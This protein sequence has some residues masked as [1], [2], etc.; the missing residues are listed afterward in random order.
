MSWFKNIFSKS[1]EAAVPHVDSSVSSSHYD[2]LKHGLAK[3]RKRW[4]DGITS[5]LIGK[6]TLDPELLEALETH[7]LEADVG[8]EMTQALIEPL[9]EGLA[10]QQLKDGDTVF[11]TI[12]QQLI[13]RLE[14]LSQPLQIPNHV[15]PFLVLMVGVNGAGKTTTM[16]KLARM[17]QLEGKK[18]M[19]AAGD[20]F[21]AAAVEQ[22]QQWGARYHI[23]VVA[24]STGADSAAVIYDAWQ[25]ACARHMDILIADTAGRLHTQSHLM[26]ELKKIK[27]VLQKLDQTLPHE[28]LLVLDAGVGQN[29]LTQARLFH[30]AMGVTGLVITKLDGTAK[31]GMV[32]PL[33]SSLSLPIRYIGVGEGVDDLRPFEAAHFV[34]AL[35]SHD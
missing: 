35:L 33:A 12:K 10:R 23:P 32:F 17:W 6:K 29:A 11:Q 1:E 24:Q 18:V 13:Q 8:V 19:M 28:I 3:T 5:L 31:G 4:L 20:T 22:L 7:L 15:R 26:E 34:E 27:R 16:A 21:R 30:E 14:P 9:V 2:R 25:A